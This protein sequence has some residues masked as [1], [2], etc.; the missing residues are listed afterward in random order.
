MGQWTVLRKI[1]RIHGAHA[2]SNLAVPYIFV[3]ED[4]FG[5]DKE[6]Y[7]N[8]VLLERVHTG[9]RSVGSQL[10]RCASQGAGR[11]QPAVGG[12]GQAATHSPAIRRRPYGV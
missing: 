7:S 11:V 12:C 10:C 3:M 6:R 4:F 5:M 2:T 1:M 9:M 8:A